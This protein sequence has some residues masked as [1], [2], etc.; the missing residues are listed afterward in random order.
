[1]YKLES[2]GIRSNIIN[3]FKNYLFDRKQRVVI[4][5]FASTFKHVHAGVPQGSVLGPFLFLL[6]INDITSCVTSCIKLFADDTSLFRIVNTNPIEEAEILS[7]DLNN[8]NNWSRQWDIKFNAAKTE[9]VIFSRRTEP[10]H[11]DIFFNNELVSVSTFHKHLGLFFSSDGKWNKHIDYIYKKA[12]QKMNILRLL[13]N[14][15]DRKSLT[16]LYISHIRPI[17]E[18]ADAVWDNCPEYAKNLLESI[19]LE[20]A[21]IITG[22]RRGTSNEKL[23]SELDWVSLDDR[24]KKHKMTLMYKILNKESPDYLYD[25][26]QPYLNIP[27][28]SRYQLRNNRIFNEPF[29]RTVSYTN[30]FFPNM[31]CEFNKISDSLVDIHSIGQFK[32]ILDR[33][34]YVNNNAN[35]NVVFKE[36]GPRK[37][38]IILCQ[39]RN[40]ASSLNFDLHNDH[41]LDYPTCACGAPLET[42]Q[43]FFFDCPRYINYR[44]DLYHCLYQHE[45]SHYDLEI[46]LNGCHDCD[47][48]TNKFIL[49]S[50][51]RYIIDTKRFS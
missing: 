50:I 45:H 37:Y 4:D 32:K 48:N 34:L 38:N 40:S 6:Y 21:R 46:I 29:C 20:A 9:S 27:N 35:V 11:P 26:V 14:K 28:E 16:V 18:Y 17:L 1:M 39:L 31:I 23:Y 36:Y 30:S 24:R 19:N 3:W 15:I 41:L 22:L 2:H 49:D 51:T 13:K 5:G 10:D 7:D 8:I 42:V 33:Q 12:N 47:T 44:Q 25:I 43:H